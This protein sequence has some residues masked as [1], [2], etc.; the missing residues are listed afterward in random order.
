ML[1]YVCFVEWILD[2]SGPV[3]LLP[4][5]PFLPC[6][7]VLRHMLKKA[8]TSN[9]AQAAVNLTDVK[10]KRDVLALSLLF[11]VDCSSCL[12]KQDVVQLKSCL[13]APQLHHYL[14]CILES[15]HPNLGQIYQRELSLCMLGT[16][17]WRVSG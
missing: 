11:V 2:I 9:T 17:S 6:N 15:R 1:G 8:M 4:H 7:L 10:V 14:F 12:C 3:V 5:L 16:H 13:L